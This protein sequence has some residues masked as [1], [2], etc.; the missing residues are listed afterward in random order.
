MYIYIYHFHL[1][2]NMFDVPA[3]VELQ[4]SNDDPSIRQSDAGR[5]HVDSDGV[6]D[7]NTDEWDTEDDHEQ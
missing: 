4:W 2:W 3:V 1:T 6:P 7:V 5:H